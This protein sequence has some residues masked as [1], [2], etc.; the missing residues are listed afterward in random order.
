MP[1]PRLRV[2]KDWVRR[3]N[4]SDFVP[5]S[6][7]A[8]TLNGYIPDL[9]NTSKFTDFLDSR[10]CQSMGARAMDTSCREPVRDMTKTM[11]GNKFDATVRSIRTFD[12]VNA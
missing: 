3:V 10:V 12:G 5:W 9:V 7:K 11:A 8:R 2:Q 4:N 6:N 1:A